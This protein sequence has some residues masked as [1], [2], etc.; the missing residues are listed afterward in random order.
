MI[1]ILIVE[2]AGLL[3]DALR[4]VLSS[5][6][7][8]TVVADL[9]RVDDIP[10]E[11]RRVHPDVVVVNSERVGPELVRL[12]A[13]AGGMSPETALVVVTGDRSPESLAAA[14]RV[15]VRGFLAADLGPEDLIDVVR[16][17]SAGERVVDAAI[18]VAALLPSDNP[19]SERER[20]VLRAVADGL[21]LQE[22]GRQ[23]HLAYGTVRNHLSRI[24]RK[25]GARNRIEAVRRAHEEGWI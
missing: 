18:A 3:R 22:I 25:T 10:Q 24:L 11:V 12:L 9:A 15:G 19:L 14:L 23:L 4:T 1:R 21:P 8:L 16:T 17:V 7:D 13:E 6:S 20:Q 5:Q 2:E